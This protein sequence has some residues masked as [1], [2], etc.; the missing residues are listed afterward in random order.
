MLVDF[1]SK[2]VFLIICFLQRARLYLQL[3]DKALAALAQE[4]S[5]AKPSLYS[6]LA[7]RIFAREQDWYGE[8]LSFSSS[9]R[10]F[11]YGRMGK[12]FWKRP[13]SSPQKFPGSVTFC[14]KKEWKVF[15][16]MPTS[17]QTTCMSF[18]VCIALAWGG[19]LGG[20]EPAVPIAAHEI[21]I[22]S[23]G[24]LFTDT[25]RVPYLPM[26]RIT[27]KNEKCDP[28][29]FTKRVVE[30]GDE[31][32]KPYAVFLAYPD[33]CQLLTCGWSM[34]I[35]ICLDQ[36]ARQ[37]RGSRCA[38]RCCTERR[39]PSFHQTNGRRKPSGAGGYTRV[40]IS[41]VVPRPCCPTPL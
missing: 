1:H 38:G 19:K 16:V 4:K 17:I 12:K 11:V 5:A 22:A 14:S 32:M 3:S 26:S 6:D 29:V 37:T 20:A 31:E 23:D 34:T 33:V 35:L 7:N 8:F 13:L 15:L 28:S 27:W 30:D 36:A 21:K 41:V 24:A 39:C 10:T 25:C 9:P 40:C 18:S 2:G